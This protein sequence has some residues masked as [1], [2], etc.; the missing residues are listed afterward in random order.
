MPD[1]NGQG[2]GPGEGRHGSPRTSGCGFLL[3]DLS[4]GLFKNLGGLPT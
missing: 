2:R 1:F 4:Q 3:C